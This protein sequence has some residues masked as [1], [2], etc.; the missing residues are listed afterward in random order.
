MEIDKNSGM[1][2]IACSYAYDEAKSKGMRRGGMPIYNYVTK[3]APEIY[4]QL[5][6][7]TYKFSVAEDIYT[8]LYQRE[9]S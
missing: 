5:M 4:E 8:P 9:C 2:G 7:K 3:R 6:N 1:W